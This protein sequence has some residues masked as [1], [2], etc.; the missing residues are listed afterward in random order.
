MTSLWSQGDPPLCLSLGE[1]PK[2]PFTARI[3][4]YVCSL[5]A[6][7]FS[8]KGWGLTDLPLRASN[9]GS[10]RP[11]VARAQK[12]ISLHP[13]LCSASKKDGL[14]A[15]SLPLLPSSPISLHEG[16][17]V[18][19]QLRASSD[20]SFIVG[21]LRARGRPGR[22]HVFHFLLLANASSSSAPSRAFHSRL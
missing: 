18:D 1:R 12:I 14:A 19:P 22:P 21:A 8:L 2:L 11:R 3:E 9:E 6:C 5:Q 4:R 7:L 13:L 20:H 16:G 17:L 15:P 10:P